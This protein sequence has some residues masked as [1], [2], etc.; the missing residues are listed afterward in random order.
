MLT[1]AAQSEKRRRQNT[2]A[3]RKRKELEFIII[4]TKLLLLSGG[5]DNNGN[6]AAEN[7]LFVSQC[8][9]VTSSSILFSEGTPS[10]MCRRQVVLLYNSRETEDGESEKSR[11]SLPHRALH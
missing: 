2:R 4:P 11:L 1:I 7:N 5:K 3:A 6:A 8:P 10:Y 9:S